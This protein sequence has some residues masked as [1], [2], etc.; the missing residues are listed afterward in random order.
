MEPNYL[1]AYKDYYRVRAER[2]ADNPN[3]Q[4]SYKAE[5]NLSAAMQSCNELIEFQDKIGNLNE[6]CANALVKDEHLMEKA[7]YEK[8]Q[9]HIRVLA[10]QRILDKIDQCSN[11]TEVI[12]LVMEE[13]NKN[14]LE[15][16]MDEAHREF[17]GDWFLMDR[18]EVYE[19]AVVPDKYKAELKS[20]ASEIKAGIIKSNAEA[21]EEAR[22]FQPDF[23][24]KPELNLEH[25]HRRL[26]PYSDAHIQ[27]QLA[28][29]KS[30]V[31]R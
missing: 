24:M 6:L 9:E 31:N 26:L 15:I 5:S 8:H 7:F 19:N 23:V 4:H 20:S 11:V 18:A 17:Q 28:K 2:F 14:S 27:E 29:Y 30:L 25:R 16:S 12:T 1:Q 3:Y 13:V 22:K 10:A 21:E